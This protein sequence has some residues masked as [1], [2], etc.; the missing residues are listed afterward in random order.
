MSA[1]GIGSFVAT[2]TFFLTAIVLTVA[3]HAITGGRA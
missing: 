2:A 3:L 1:R